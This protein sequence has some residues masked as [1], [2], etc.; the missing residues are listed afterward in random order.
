MS[1]FGS[2]VW[3]WETKYAECGLFVQGKRAFLKES[4]AKNFNLRL[5]WSLA[6]MVERGFFEIYRFV[7]LKFVRPADMMLV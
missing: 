1:I 6:D 2:I 5:T 7:K 3:G 4:C